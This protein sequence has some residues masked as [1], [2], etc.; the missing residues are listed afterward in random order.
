MRVPVTETVVTEIETPSSTMT[1]AGLSAQPQDLS[2]PGEWGDS[3]ATHWICIV[4]L[5][6]AMMTTYATTAI[7]TY[8]YADDYPLLLG[9]VNRGAWVQEVY[10]S[11]GRPVLGWLTRLALRWADAVE[12]LRFV[13]LAIG[14]QLLGLGMLIYFHLVRLRLPALAAL[15]TAVVIVTSPPFQIQVSWATYVVM[16]AA[17]AF[18]YVTYRL[19]S[20]PMRLGSWRFYAGQITAV[21]CTMLVLATYQPSA[22]FYWFWFLAEV[23]LAGHTLRRDLLR[24]VQ[25]C[26]PFALGGGAYFAWWK[27]VGK[28]NTRTGLDPDRLGKLAWFYREV[29]PETFNFHVF[30]WPLLVG[31]GVIVGVVVVIA[32]LGRGKWHQRLGKLGL[33]GLILPVSYVVNLAVVTRFATYRT[34]MALMSLAALLLCYALW[35]LI[36]KTSRL[37]RLAPAALVAVMGIV[38]VA[39]ASY[40]VNYYMVWPQSIEYAMLKSQLREFDPRRHRKIHYIHNRFVTRFTPDN[41]YMEF[42][43]P[44]S[45]MPSDWGIGRSMTMLAMRHLFADLPPARRSVPV[46][47]FEY[48]APPPPDPE[49]LVVDMRRLQSYR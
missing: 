17:A 43:V 45:N 22:M 41:Y 36:A 7:A 21:A 24:L 2:L 26:I 18:T 49:A 27:A 6:G 44:S 29:V 8:G 34:R 14:I 48:N 40:T 47:I 35:L 28:T 15:L 42:G 25:V 11:G 9:S 23:L 12:N 3:A 33:A 38:L 10:N 31:T 4:L 5:I 32:V 37:H 30:H 1:S 13:R 46:E 39:R 20:G 19:A 16:V